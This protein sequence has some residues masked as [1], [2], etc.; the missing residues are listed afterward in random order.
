MACILFVVPRFHTN[1]F[2]ATKAL[3]E[4]GHCVAVFAETTSRIEDHR[5]V[6]PEVFGPEP[7]VARLHRALTGLRPD[8]IF[9]RYPSKL[10]KAVHVAARKARLRILSYDQRPLTQRRGLGKRLSYRLEQRAWERV[11][12]VRGLDVKAPT[13]PAAHYLPWPIEELPV[14]QATYRAM[15]EGP[16]R[17]LCVGK[18]AQVRKRQDALIDAM[19]TLPGGAMLTLVGATDRNISGA[20]DAHLARLQKAV[21]DHPW[22]TLRSDVSYGDMPSLFAAHHVCVLPSVHETLGWAP[23]EA[24]AYGTIPI[25][26]EGAGSAGYITSGQ[27]GFRVDVSVQGALEGRLGALIDDPAL[28]LRLSDGA[29]QTAKSD[30]SPKL[31]VS[32]VEALLA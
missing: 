12:P 10:S 11:T 30:L 25:I 1:L 9:A 20:D 22:I 24:M 17:V 5:L 13:D 2:F 26:S 23:I 6:T 19:Q 21:A 28:R 7:D 14:P 27:N 3:I 32:R 15:A 29:R 31:F 8:L 18:L 16:V 4:A